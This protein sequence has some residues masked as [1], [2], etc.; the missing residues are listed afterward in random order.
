VGKATVLYLPPRSQNP[1]VLRRVIS[2]RRSH[3]VYL[4]SFFSP[5]FTLQVLLLR[6]FRLLPRLPFVI[7]PRG[8]FSP[9]ALELKKLKKRTYLLGARA[10]HLYSNL[11]W[12][13]SATLEEEHIRAWFG[14]EALVHIGPDLLDPVAS[15]P[16][17]ELRP[18]KSPGKLKIVFVSRISRKKNLLLALATL[19]RV[20]GDVE[21]D[22]Y[23]PIEDGDYWRECKACI[24]AVPAHVSVVYH[25]PIL[26]DEV[27]SMLGRSHLF[28]MPTLGENHGHAIVEALRA[29]CPVLISDETPWRDLEANHAGYA[30]SLTRKDLLTEALQTFIDM[31]EARYAEWSTGARR[32]IQQALDPDAASELTRSL[33][34]QAGEGTTVE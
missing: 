30:I 26:H 5:V 10:L 28:F 34:K 23:G 16:F 2:D 29:G 7:A 32:Y 27:A 18:V 15:S 25:G 31:D 1:L 33:F 19:S 12:H 17:Q 14:Q 11:R 3:L 20:T 6:K 8:E 13:A 9:N 4:N 21:F 24:A 22:I